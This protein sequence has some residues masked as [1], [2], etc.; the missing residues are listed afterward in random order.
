MAK[1]PCASCM[2]RGRYEKNPKSLL[3]R[4]WRWHAKWCPGWKRY[5]KAL[6]EEERTALLEHLAELDSQRAS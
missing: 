1:A 6:P 4:L 3:G 2:F 5:M